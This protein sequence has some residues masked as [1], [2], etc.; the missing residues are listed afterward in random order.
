MTSSTSST[1]S[2]S[3]KSRLVSLTCNSVEKNY[4]VMSWYPLVVCGRLVVFT[5]L[6][7]GLEGGSLC[8]SCR[9]SG[10]LCVSG[11]GLCAWGVE[12]ST[13]KL[14]VCVSCS[15]KTVLKVYVVPHGVVI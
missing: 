3:G 4:F 6:R 10:G 11:E 13:G 15:G 7:G 1:L 9:D 14:C 5:G 12:C 8:L 2:F